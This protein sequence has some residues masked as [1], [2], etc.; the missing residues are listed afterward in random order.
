MLTAARPEVATETLAVFDPSL[1]GNP[2]SIVQVA[3]DRERIVSI[4]AFVIETNVSNENVTV[5]EF[6]AVLS[7]LA[8][9]ELAFTFGHGFP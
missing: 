5:R 3:R 6:L 2:R 9:S 8:L 4:A 7:L 1:A